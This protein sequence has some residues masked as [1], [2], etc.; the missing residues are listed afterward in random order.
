MLKKQRVDKL[1]GKEDEGVSWG[2][3]FDEDEIAAFQKKQEE[4]SDEASG[5]GSSDE[6]D[7]DVKFLNVEK[8]KQRDDLSDKQKGMLQKVE[9]IRR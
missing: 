7:E 1:Q 5:E 6:D 3:G 4:E 9:G 2:M 8:L